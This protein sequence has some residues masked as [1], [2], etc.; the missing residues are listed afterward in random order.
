MST[1]QIADHFLEASEILQKF[2]N[3][4]NFE[5]IKQ[6]GLLMTESLNQGGK[7]LSCGNGG[8]MCDAMHFAEELTGRYRD[9]RKAL[10]AISISDNSHISCVSN[11]Y[12][13]DFVFSRYLE[14]LGKPGDILL[15]IS[16]S[17][18]SKNVLLAIE[19][20]QKIG[21]K[22][23]GLTGKDGGKMAN[24]CD[25]EIRAPHSNYADRAQEI[26]IKVIHTLI[27]FIEKNIEL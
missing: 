13:Y 19:T 25:V 7:I 15:A 26:H 21:M 6:A 27:D 12:G 11:D 8:S 22:V 14:A 18:N 4:E 1:K 24:H 2:N 5:K 17:G 10:P 16:T 23:V 3:S 9:N 20:A